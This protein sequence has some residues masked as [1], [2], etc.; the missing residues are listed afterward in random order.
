MELSNFQQAKKHL[1]EYLELKG[2]RKTVERFAILEE[3]YARDDHFEAEELYISLKLKKIALSQATV[4][5]TLEVLV[6]AE[7]IIK[8]QFGNKISSRYEKAQG[9]K[10]HDHLICTDCE[11]KSNVNVIEESQNNN[12]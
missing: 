3:I 5:N 4:Y 6:E 12:K 9:R 10:Q 11:H 7:L 8:H 2:L 1:T